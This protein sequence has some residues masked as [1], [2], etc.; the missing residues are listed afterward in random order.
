MTKTRLIGI[1]VR[2]KTNIEKIIICDNCHLCQNNEL[3]EEFKYLYKITFH[4]HQSH[5]I[6]WTRQKFKYGIN[7]THHSNIF[8]FHICTSCSC[9]QCNGDSDKYS[10]WEYTGHILFCKCRRIQ[11]WMKLMSGTFIILFQD[12]VDIGGSFHHIY[13]SYIYTTNILLL[14]IHWLYL[15][16]RHQKWSIGTAEYKH[17]F[18]KRF[19][20]LAAIIWL[21]EL[22]VHGGVLSL[23]INAAT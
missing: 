11:M 5:D 20:L 10:T 23:P 8:I 4:Q 9:F 17:K 21:L 2:H 7:G 19:I 15:F 6:L 22:C 14:R 18:N 13:S 16:I 3:I 12:Y 1:T